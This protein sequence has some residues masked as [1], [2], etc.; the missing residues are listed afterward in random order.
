MTNTSTPRLTRNQLMRAAL[1]A[2]A[3]GWHVFPLIAGSKRPAVKDWESRS[4]T[5]RRRI[6]RCWSSGAYNVGVACGPSGLLVVDLDVPKQ[7]ADGGQATQAPA[8]WRLPGVQDGG[9]VLEVLTERAGEP[10]PWETYTVATCSGGTH[11]YFRQPA[12]TALR[13]TSRRLGWLIDTRGHGGYVVA[14]GSVVDGQSYV[15]DHDARPRPL[16]GWLLAQLAEAQ[17]A[18][19]P[20]PDSARLRAQ[21]RQRAAYSHRALDEALN[22]VLSAAAGDKVGAGRNDTLNR[23][24]YRLGPLVSAGLLPERLVVDALTAAATAVG[25]DQREADR[26]IGS[27]LRAGMAKTAGSGRP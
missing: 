3:R 23:A 9:D 26:T 12:G 13:N 4:T 24:A 6:E 19:A 10:M 27:G 22:Q 18:P 14:A 15:V 11:L 2:A 20:P 1:D 21:I 25:L 7:A 16:P 5:D 17:P 8:Q